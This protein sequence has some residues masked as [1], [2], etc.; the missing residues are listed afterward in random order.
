MKSRVI[1]LG[2]YLYQNID[3]GVLYSVAQVQQNNQFYIVRIGEA[4]IEQFITVNEALF[5]LHQFMTKYF[6]VVDMDKIFNDCS[7]EI[8]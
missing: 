8:K 3:T 1:K 7:S 4:T 5:F 2:N 6:T